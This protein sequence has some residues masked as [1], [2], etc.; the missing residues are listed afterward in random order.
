M[1]KYLQLSDTNIGEGSTEINMFDKAERKL[2]VVK[3]NFKK[4][5]NPLLCF[6]SDIVFAKL[7]DEIPEN[8]S[9]MFIQFNETD[10]A[11]ISY[12]FFEDGPNFNITCAVIMANALEIGEFAVVW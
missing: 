6:K 2:K 10:I 12:N 7:V 8:S 4:V 9:D 3:S 1:T 5:I 11:S